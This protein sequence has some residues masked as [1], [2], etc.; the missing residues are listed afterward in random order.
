MKLKWSEYI[1]SVNS[2]DGEKVILQ[3]TLNGHTVTMSTEIMNVLSSSINKNTKDDPL[4]LYIQIYLKKLTKLEILVPQKQDETEKYIQ[5]ISKAQEN[6][7][8]NFSLVLVTTTSCQFNCSYCFEQGIKRQEL[9]DTKTAERIILWCQKYL[10]THP[11]CQNW[12][13]H[14]IGGEPLLNK[15]IIKFI[16]PKLNQIASEKGIP[17]TL[18]LTTNGTLLD[19]E[20][21]RFLK[22]FNLDTVNISVDGPKEIHDKRRADKSGQSSFEKIFKNIKEGLKHKLFKKLYLSI[23][24]D[25]QNINSLPG[26]FDFLAENNLQEKV[27][28][29]FN[30]IYISTSEVLGKNS[31]VSYYHKYDLSENKKA[32]KY[33]WLCQEAKKRGL[34]IPKSWQI[35]P[36]CVAQSNSSAVIQPNGSLLKCPRGIGHPEF[37]FGNIVST[38]EISDPKFNLPTSLDSCFSKKCPLIPLCNGGCRLHG[39]ISN[40]NSSKIHCRKI[41][42]EKVNKGLLQLNFG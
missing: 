23:T 29:V 39:N 5:F 27:N 19:L 35:G 40:K 38:K 28:L 12:H 2:A 6:S 32:E 7:N 4:P 18:E 8:K 3:N 30:M 34:V 37:T 10:D 33:L 36:V 16:I 41:F 14:F 22:N 24:C 25:K 31:S 42:I 15:E 21:L 26:L 1:L 13:I 9:M 11:N 17:L 20:I